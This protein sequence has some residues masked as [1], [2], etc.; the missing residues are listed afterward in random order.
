[1]SGIAQSIHERLDDVIAVIIVESGLPDAL[2]GS[3]ATS[4]AAGSL[5]FACEMASLSSVTN[6]E[7]D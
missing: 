4:D 2:K 3:R 7:T 5:I 1:V 6:G